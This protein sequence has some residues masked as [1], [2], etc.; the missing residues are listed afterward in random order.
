MQQREVSYRGLSSVSACTGVDTQTPEERLAAVSTS[1]ICLHIAIPAFNTGSDCRLGPRPLFQV[2]PP[3]PPPKFPATGGVGPQQSRF[4]ARL[5]WRAV[6]RP[7][8]VIGCELHP[9]RLT[10]IAQN[11]CPPILRH[12]RHRATVRT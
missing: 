12:S 11:L 3:D 10:P 5:A 4:A 2:P 1:V 9:Q 8:R 7:Q 6:P